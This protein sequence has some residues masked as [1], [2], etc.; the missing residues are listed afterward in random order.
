[1]LISPHQTS[2]FVVS[3]L[4][5]NLSLGDLPV[6]L[7][8][9][10]DKAPVEDILPIFFKTVISESSFGLKFQFVLVLFLIPN[11]DRSLKSGNFPVI[12]IF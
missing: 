6:N 7:P 1:M 3:S 4:T 10:T 8:V 12:F 5:I 9:L 2:S 11:F